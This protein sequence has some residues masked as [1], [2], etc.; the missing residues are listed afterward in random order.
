MR[1]ANACKYYF[2]TEERMAG[3]QSNPTPILSVVVVYSDTSDE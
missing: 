1:E 3:V 2:E